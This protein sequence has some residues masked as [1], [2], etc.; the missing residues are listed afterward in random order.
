MESR[1]SIIKMIRIINFKAGTDD[2]FW[3]RKELPEDQ[4][5]NL[6]SDSGEEEGVSE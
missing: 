5:M 6:D 1:V 4:R 2:S 3:F